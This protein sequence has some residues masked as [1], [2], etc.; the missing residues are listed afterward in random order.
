M[1]SRRSFVLKE[2]AACLPMPLRSLS[3]PHSKMTPASDAESCQRAVQAIWRSLD[4][5]NLV[6]EQARGDLATVLEPLTALALGERPRRLINTLRLP[7]PIDA[8]HLYWLTRR[9]LTLVPELQ[10]AAIAL[11]K[12]G[13]NPPAPLSDL[14]TSSKEP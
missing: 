6:D 14:A 10:A 8:S 5:H 13:G 9:L 3:Y 4:E 11:S 2:R 1:T 12:P 7:N